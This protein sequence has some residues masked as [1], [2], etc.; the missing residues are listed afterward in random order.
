MINEKRLCKHYDLFSERC[1]LFQ[2]RCEHEGQ[3]EMCQIK[4]YLEI[5]IG[6]IN[7]NNAYLKGDENAR[8][9]DN[10]K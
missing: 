3:R 7:E 9:K 1:L 4:N 8:N 10:K 2:A 5:E 6:E